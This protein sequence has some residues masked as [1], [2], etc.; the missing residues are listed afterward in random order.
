MPDHFQP[1]LPESVRLIRIAISIQSKAVVIWQLVKLYSLIQRCSWCFW[2]CWLFETA[3]DCAA[4]LAF[5]IRERTY[6]RNNARANKDWYWVRPFAGCSDIPAAQVSSRF[7]C[8][9]TIGWILSF[10]T[11]AGE[12]R[13]GAQMWTFAMVYL[14][15]NHWLGH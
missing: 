12:D 5:Q 3:A 14:S 11:G 10:P 13:P 9:G 4:S 8:C 15:H 7:C 6:Q 1:V 2:G